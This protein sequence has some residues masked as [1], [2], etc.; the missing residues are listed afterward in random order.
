MFRLGYKVGSDASRI[1]VCAD[2]HGFGRT[3]QEFNGA[4]ESYELLCRGYVPVARTNDLV[5]ARDFF[6]PIGKGSDGLCSTDPVELTHA[7][8]CGRRQS[9]LGRARRR[10]AYLLHAGDLRGNHGHEQRRWQRIAAARD[11]T[12][13][14]FQRAHQLPHRDAGLNLAQPFLRLLPLRI[15]TDIARRLLDRVLQFWISLLPSFSQLFLR[16]SERLAFTQPVQTCGV[17]AQC[18]ITVTPD[19]I[20]NP[21]D[22]RFDI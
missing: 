1:A 7:E 6:S 19:V 14:R 2:D 15:A 22:Y 10:D 4:I 5:H 18:A 20:H 11:I 9:C 8:E 16:D 21:T 13:H 17:A 12:A 3:R